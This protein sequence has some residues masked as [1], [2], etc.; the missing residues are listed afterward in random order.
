MTLLLTSVLA[1]DT[2][3][4]HIIFRWNGARLRDRVMLAI[5]RSGDG[6]V[7][8]VLGLALLLNG[9]SEAMRCVATG[10]IAFAIHLP[11]Y[12]IVKTL[13]S[14]PR[15]FETLAGVKNLITV[16]DRFSF[17]SG[18]TASA[19]LMT[20]LCANFLP[21]SS[22]VMIPWSFLIAISRVYLGVHFPLD[23][24]AGAVWGIIHARLGIWIFQL[25][26]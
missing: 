5:T 1:W 12:K 25:L 23:V 26:S 17:P 4:F 15:P 7:W 22:Y 14:R 20:T 6:Y 21:E 18:H 24:T 16:P 13:V 11:V 19:F 2:R 10:A 9:S 8:G 3:L